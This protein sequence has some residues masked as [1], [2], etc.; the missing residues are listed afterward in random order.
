MTQPQKFQIEVPPAT[1]GRIAQR[2][3]DLAPGVTESPAP[4][5][6]PLGDLI[7]QRSQRPGPRKLEYKMP[8]PRR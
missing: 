1:L 7:A 6:D 5:T 8:D 3:K 2:L 4:Q